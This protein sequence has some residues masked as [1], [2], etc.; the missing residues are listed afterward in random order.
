MALMSTL[1]VLIVV[2]PQ[3]TDF[4][5]ATNIPH[6]ETNILIFN[7]LDIETCKKIVLCHRFVTHFPTRAFELFEEN[8]VSLTPFLLKGGK[9]VVY[10]ATTA[11]TSNYDLVSQYLWR[12]N[13]KQSNIKKMASLLHKLVGL[14]LLF[15]GMEV[16]HEQ[17][18]RFTPSA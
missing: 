16:R 4:V 6:C 14:P 18:S 10:I 5:L 2:S 17:Q 12:T 3:R 13:G 11:A 15:L 8:C 1:S 7:S 9:T